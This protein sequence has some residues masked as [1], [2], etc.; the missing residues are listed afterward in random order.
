[1][2]KKF[3][4]SILAVSAVIFLFIF[5]YTKKIETFRTE[6]VTWEILKE[7]ETV[8]EFKIN[9]FNFVQQK[10]LSNKILELN[11]NEI[12][13][14]GFLLKELNKKDTIYLITETQTEVCFMCNHDEH[15]NSI[16]LE[17]AKNNKE[18]RKIGNGKLIK[19]RG[20]FRIKNNENTKFLYNIENPRLN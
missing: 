14:E 8:N 19:I 11:G 3:L 17:N 1:M 4:Y 12:S 6:D 5:P 10:K 15:Y 7:T 18:F 20:I 13:I 2:N 9:N 16:L